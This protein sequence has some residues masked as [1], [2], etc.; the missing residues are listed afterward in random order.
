MSDRAQL[1]DS[2]RDVEHLESLLS[3]PTDALVEMMR[4]VKGDIAILGVG[5][6]MGP[7]L[8]RMAKRATD[9]AGLARR[10]LGV[11]RFSSGALEERLRTH[12]IETIRADVLDARAVAALPDVENI[13]YM[14]GMKFGTT[15]KQPMTWAINAGVPAVV[16]QHFRGRR[17]VVFSTGNV[18]GLTPSDGGGSRETD[19]LDPVGEYANSALGRERIFEYYATAFNSPT[20]IY[21][22][23]YATEMRYGVLV[24]LAQ[25]VY[26]GE[27]INVTMGYANCLWQ[28]DAN[29]MALRGLEAAD[30]PATVLN[31]AGPELLRIREV[32]GTYARIMNKPVEFVGQEATDALLSNGSLG[33]QRLGTPR[34]NAEQMIRWIAD[35]VMR[36][37][38][39]LGKPTHFESRDGKF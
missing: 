24:D 9:A 13:I 38:D 37:G 12:G 4:R 14:V 29:A 20:T 26:R 31:A 35:W 2:I 32:C 21:R 27:P 30:V 23:N 15:G 34:V 16:A 39:Q 18:Y 1:C 3:E 28:A 19:E 33:H 10:I 36:G 5:G 11:A 7:T 17:M 8:A 22:L 25:Q 6:K